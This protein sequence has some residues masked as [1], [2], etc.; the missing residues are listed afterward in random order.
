M[1]NGGYT[2]KQRRRVY[3]GRIREVASI[4]NVKLCTV[5]YESP[6]KNGLCERVHVLTDSML[7]KLESDHGRVNSYSFLSWANMANNNLQMWNSSSH[8]LVFGVSPKLPIIMQDSLPAL[9]GLTTGKTFVKHI[10]ALHA[11]R[12]HLSKVNLIYV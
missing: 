3:F 10:N 6:L 4:L 11:A 2:D 5:A 8:Q 7:I 1:N 12:K 9:E